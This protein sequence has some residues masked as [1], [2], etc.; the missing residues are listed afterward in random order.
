MFNIHYFYK[1]ITHL[2]MEDVVS[3]YRLLTWFFPPSNRVSVFLL[4]NWFLFL[5]KHCLIGFECSI[6]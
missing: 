5:V 2:R 6:Q 4:L 3:F 1:Q